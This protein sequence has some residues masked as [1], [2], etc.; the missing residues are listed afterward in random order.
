MVRTRAMTLE[1]MAA[2]SRLRIEGWRAAYA[3]IVPRSY[4]DAMDPDEEAARRR[5]WLATS[6]GRVRNLVAV[7]PG[8]PAYEESGAGP[9]GTGNG[10]IRAGGARGADGEIVGWAAFGPYRGEPETTADGELYA[11]YVRPDRIGTGVGR[12][13]I[14][15][16]IDRSAG[17][18]RRRLLLWVLADNHRARGFYARAGFTADGAETTDRYDGLPLTELRYVRPLAPPPGPA[19]P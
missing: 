14:A 3:G 6:A 5:E 17:L 8:G 15:A 9:E 1:D 16:V 13:L 7:Q 2:V 10:G 4:L 11:L 12:A 19:A 18:G